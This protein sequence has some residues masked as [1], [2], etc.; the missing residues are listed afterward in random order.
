MEPEI[1]IPPVPVLNEEQ[2]LLLNEFQDS[3]P[4]PDGSLPFQDRIYETQ[5]YDQGSGEHYFDENAPD[6]N[7]PGNVWF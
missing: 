1:A 4:L 3:F 5:H 7:S 6:W 2:C